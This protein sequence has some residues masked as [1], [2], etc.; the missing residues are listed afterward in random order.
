MTVDILGHQ[1]TI[2]VPNIR[3]AQ[4]SAPQLNISI[5]NLGTS[6]MTGT[7]NEGFLQC[8]W[9]GI[10]IYKSRVITSFAANPM[11][12]QSLSITM[13]DIFTQSLGNKHITCWLN[14]DSAYYT[15]EA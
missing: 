3:V 15:G 13:K 5:N 10:N 8:D 4:Y 14:K 2:N 9:N 6:L 1:V 12:P 7:F 11:I